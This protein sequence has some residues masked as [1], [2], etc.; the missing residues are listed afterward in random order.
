MAEP[1]GGEELDDASRL[2]LACGFCC[3]STLFFHAK[4]KPNEIEP[5]RETGFAI[6]EA[7]EVTRFLQPCANLCGTRC[8]LY[9]HWRPHICGEFRC[10]LLNRLDA[11]DVS[12][13]DALATIDKAR[14]LLSA[15][16]EELRTLRAMRRTASDMQERMAEAPLPAQDGALMARVVIALRFLDQNFRKDGKKTLSG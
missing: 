9:S 10:T 5:A 6:E 8:T 15:L 3:D 16:P 4:L 11:D 14:S 2:C 1:C 12:I 13:D 7:D